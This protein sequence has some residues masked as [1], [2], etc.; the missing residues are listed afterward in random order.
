[1]SFARVSYLVPLIRHRHPCQV[2]TLNNTHGS[3]HHIYKNTIISWQCV[4]SRQRWFR[5]LEKVGVFPYY[6]VLCSLYALLFVLYSVQC[7]T[8]ALTLV[9]C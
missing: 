1:M 4:L 9:N 8:L 5:C 7:R 3:Y 2:N 6:S